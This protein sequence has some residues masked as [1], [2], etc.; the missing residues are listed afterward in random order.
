VSG[1]HGQR[2]HG[3]A[4]AVEHVV[5]EAWPRDRSYEEVAV[6][7]P[8]SF[9]LDVPRAALVLTDPQVDFLSPRG[10][11]WSAVGESV[12]RNHTVQNI[13]RLLKAA[14]QADMVVAIAPHYYYS[15]D[16]RWGFGGPLERLMDRIVVLD[17]GALMVTEPETSGADLLPQF[18]P[19][20][21]A[22]KTIVAAPHKVYGPG[23]DDL[24]WRLR[25]Y[26][27]DQVILAGMSAN[28]CVESHLRAL[29]ER[30]F[31]VAVVKDATAAATLADDDGYLA[32]L[33]NF[34]YLANALWSTDETLRHI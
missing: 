22:R 30:G 7:A 20:L 12:E 28:L 13:E 23:N 24:A 32:A 34:R 1:E 4:L 9:R 10:A 27:I 18:K 21:L 31:E 26:Q 14:R 6:S 15:S 29:L 8:E 5:V 33:I 3:V 17:R 19:Y 16:H 2:R 25:D 11:T